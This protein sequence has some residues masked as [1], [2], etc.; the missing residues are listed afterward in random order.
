MDQE[1]FFYRP[2]DH[3]E[4]GNG[5]LRQVYDERGFFRKKKAKK[6]LSAFSA[7]VRVLLLKL[8]C[9]WFFYIFYFEW[10]WK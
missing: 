10:A 7:L 9:G 2:P 8:S 6:L 5:H 3:L 4:I 1:R